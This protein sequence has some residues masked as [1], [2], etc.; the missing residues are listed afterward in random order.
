MVSMKKLLT[1]CIA[2]AM[3]LS[4]S[5]CGSGSGHSS[6]AGGKGDKVVLNVWAW[7]PNYTGAVKLFEQKN[8]SIKVKITN[9]GTSNKE[10]QA[11]SNAISAGSGAPDVA[12]IEYAAVPQ[13]AMQGSL[14]KLSGYGANSYKD[15]YTKGAWNSV[16]VNGDIYALPV[17]TGPMALFYN[18]DIF[19]RAGVTEA[20][21]TLEQY[22]E[23]AKKIH[24]LGS[25]YYII[26]DTGG[27]A[28]LV[29]LMWAVGSHPFTVK[30]KTI[31][32]NFDNNP[33]LDR[34]LDIWQKMLDE[35]LLD[36]KSVEWSDEW[37]HSLNNGHIASL[38]CGAWMSSMLD[39]SAPD[40]KGQWRV[41][42]MPMLDEGHP[43]NGEDGGS[44]LAI[45][46]SSKQADAAYKFIDF[47]SHNS[48]GIKARVEKGQFPADKRTLQSKDF[49]ERSDPYFG[50]QKI[51]EVLAKAPDTVDTKWQFLPYH[52]YAQTTSGDAIGK[53]VAGNVTLKE[54]LN[55]WRKGLLEYGKNQGFEVKE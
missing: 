9:V 54:A 35:G 28:P 40:A 8:P 31:G 50:D 55:N 38:L 20:P 16:N 23:A 33:K 11:L 36:T 25:D 6:S 29:N 5:A 26:N 37:N 53:A 52:V 10:Y 17:D 14:K 15:F 32:I 45:L 49:E 21:K 39:D 27:F 47:V 34:L 22:Y 43:S 46:D 1:G 44:S 7:D 48:A 51:N 18:K 13:F 24:A 42:P 30:G 2:G 12:Q 41:A 3:L 19:D 4:I